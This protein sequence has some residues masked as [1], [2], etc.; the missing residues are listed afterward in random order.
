MVKN[1]KV[2]VDDYFSYKDIHSGEIDQAFQPLFNILI[3]LFRPID[4]DFFRIIAGILICLFLANAI[5]TCRT[6]LWFILA[7]TFTWYLES[8]AITHIRMGLA[9]AFFAFIYP[10]SRNPLW[11]FLLSLIHYAALLHLLIYIFIRSDRVQIAIAMGFCI[12]FYSLLPWFEYFNELDQYRVYIIPMPDDYLELGFFSIIAFAS[13]L[14]VSSRIFWR[15]ALV[16]ALAIFAK[17][18][19][20]IELGGRLSSILVLYSVL[21]AAHPILYKEVLSRTSQNI[22][23][24]TRSRITL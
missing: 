1:Y 21:I 16:A 6:R 12:L 9:F 4:Y 20:G 24:Y 22:L 5:F 13:L 3:A 8:L 17:L 19:L 10:R 11:V 14:M 7:F 23:L 15:F 2:E 18:F